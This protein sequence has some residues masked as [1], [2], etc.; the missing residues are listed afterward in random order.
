MACALGEPKQ[1][2]HPTGSS[3]ELL[4]AAERRRG[5]VVGV[6]TPRAAPALLVLLL[7]PGRL[8]VEA[9][10]SLPLSELRRRRRSMGIIAPL[11][12]QLVREAVR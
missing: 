10:S 1:P 4:A 11:V 6:L 2:P 3:S 12:R 5:P 8:L 7:D 9:K